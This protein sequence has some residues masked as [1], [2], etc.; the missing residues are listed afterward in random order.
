MPVTVRFGRILPSAINVS[1][2]LKFV[3]LREGPLSKENQSNARTVENM[4]WKTFGM[5]TCRT[6]QVALGVT[7]HPTDYLNN[8]I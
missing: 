2:S 7:N 5:I 8:S 6:L 4:D 3:F 1:L